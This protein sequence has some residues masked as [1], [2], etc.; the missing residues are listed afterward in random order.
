MSATENVEPGVIAARTE[1]QGRARI[2]IYWEEYAE[3]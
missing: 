3:R 1:L 2:K